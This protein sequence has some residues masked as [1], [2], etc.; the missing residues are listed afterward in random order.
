MKVDIYTK[1]CLTVIAVCLACRD[2]ETSHL[3]D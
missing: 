3:N 1:A 2:L